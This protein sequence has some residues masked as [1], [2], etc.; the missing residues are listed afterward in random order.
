[1]SALFR[2]WVSGVR[3]DLSRAKRNAFEYGA[4]C[5]FLG[6]D[7]G[8]CYSQPHL[9]ELARAGWRAAHLYLKARRVALTCHEC[10]QILPAFR[11]GKQA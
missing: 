2:D 1:M 4:H 8:Q 11:R 10:D 3:P 5:R 9:R 7:T 6:L